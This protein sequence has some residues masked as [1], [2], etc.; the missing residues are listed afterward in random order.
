M[1]AGLLLAAGRASRFGATK[2]LAE[3][4]G[5]ALVVRA[6][7]Q[8]VPVCD[9]AVTVVVGADGLQVAAAL[10]AALPAVQVVDNPAWAEG[11]GRSL[12]AGVAA[13]PGDAA[14]VLVLLADQPAVTTAHLAGL[15]AAWR[16]A[17]D[18]VVAAAFAGTVGVP[19]VLPRRLFA[20]LQSLHGDQGARALL[21]AEPEL[22]AVPLPEAALDVD[23]P[24][25]LARLP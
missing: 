13:L 24:D 6:A 23:T 16:A 2:V 15:A 7:R 22:V 20:T 11:L 19:A 12:A 17:P 9:G 8:L 18:R 1:I 5:E 25:D 10:R 14:A 4:H 21:Q 3:Y